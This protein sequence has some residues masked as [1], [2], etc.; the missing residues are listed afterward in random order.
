MGAIDWGLQGKF[1]TRGRS[2]TEEYQGRQQNTRDREG[3]S[4]R[5]IGGGNTNQLKAEDQ[6]DLG[7]I[8]GVWEYKLG[9]RRPGNGWVGASDQSGGLMQID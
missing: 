6:G 5:A 2:F 7:F 9:S 8:R 1:E 3:V 4:E